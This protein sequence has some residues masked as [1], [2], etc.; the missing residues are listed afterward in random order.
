MSRLVVVSNRVKGDAGGLAVGIEQAL[1]QTGGLWFGWSGNVSA[2]GNES[3]SR[4]GDIDYHL[5]DLAQE[6]LDRYYSGYANGAIWPLFHNRLD[7]AHFERQDWDA[8]RRVNRLFAEKLLPLLR[9]D[10]II[11]VHDYHLMLLAA[12]L[13]A[14]GVRNQ[15]GFFLHIPFPSPDLLFALPS[16]REVL[17]GLAAFDLT[18]F[19]TEDDV[20]NF[21]RGMQ[22][23]GLGRR[24]D[25]RIV[26]AFGTSF[27]AAAFP[28]G[29][30]T[31]RFAELASRAFRNSVVQR[32]RDSLNGRQLLIG[33]DRLD[34]SKGLSQ[35]IE[36]FSDFLETRP[37]MRRQVIYLQVTPKSRSEVSGYPQ[38]QRAIAELAGRVNG[39]YGDVDWTPMRYV[40]RPLGRPALAGL[41]RASRVALVTPLRD[42]MNLVAKEYVAAQDPADPGVLILSR[43]AG[44]AHELDGALLVNP[45]DREEMSGAIAQALEMP[46][47]ERLNR[48]RGMF[49][50]ILRNDVHHWR[51]RYLAELTAG[52][53]EPLAITA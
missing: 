15:I 27:R 1:K 20:D 52:R 7:L 44:A 11:W 43:F 29:I 49:A 32:T 26:D 19:Q 37:A 16:H 10:D 38:M 50:R 41:Y 2:S 17:R 21:A 14:L 33:V 3:S 12:E 24:V 4:S 47:A 39:A 31:A 8:Y 18:G 42:G 53:Q 36:A 22:R 48:W 35:R 6:D 51:E 45:Y 28:I 23:D 9:P 34:Y 30:E 5:I 46:L 25:G 40:N 13:R